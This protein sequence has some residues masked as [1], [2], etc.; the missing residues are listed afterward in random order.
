MTER[1]YKTLEWFHIV[2]YG[3][4]SCVSASIDAVL[5]RHSVPTIVHIQQGMSFRS[6]MRAGQRGERIDSCDWFINSIIRVN[7]AAGNMINK[8]SISSYLLNTTNKL[9]RT[10]EQ[11][12]SQGKRMLVAVEED[13]LV[14][15]KVKPRKEWRQTWGGLEKYQLVGPLDQYDRIGHDLSSGQLL[16]RLIHTSPNLYSFPER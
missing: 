8:K 4:G 1:H 9:E 5:E 7:R 14:G 12:R 10:I 11:C 16:R 13:H 15:L 3:K 6:L 2:G